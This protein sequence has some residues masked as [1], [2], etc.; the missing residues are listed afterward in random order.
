MRRLKKIALLSGAFIGILVLVVAIVGYFVAER[1]FFD[2]KAIEAR[3]SKAMGME[4]TIEHLRPGILRG[5]AFEGTDIVI[6]SPRHPNPHVTIEKVSL[7]LKTRPLLTKQVIIKRLHFKRP[8]VRIATIPDPK[9]IEIKPLLTKLLGVASQ[10]IEQGFFLEA[11]SMSIQGGRVIFYDDQDHETVLAEIRD[12]KAKLSGLKVRAPTSFAVSGQ[13]LFKGNAMPFSFRGVTNDLPTRFDPA[14][15]AI[16]GT[17]CGSM[18]YRSKGVC[19]QLMPL[20]AALGQ[21]QLLRSFHS[22]GLGQS[23]Y[24]S[25]RMNSPLLISLTIIVPD[26]K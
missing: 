16:E 15:V 3:L 10:A 25:E 26:G 18:E 19:A 23:R 2:K 17:G 9:T 20:T 8:I 7:G 11:R 21:K 5:V 22:R 13:L 12:L 6:R 1:Y 14:L 24:W 4:V